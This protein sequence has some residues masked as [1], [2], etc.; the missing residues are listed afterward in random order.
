[1]QPVLERGSID[2]P[3]TFD[4]GFHVSAVHFLF[5]DPLKGKRPENLILCLSRMHARD[6]KS[7]YGYVK[8]NVAINYI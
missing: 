2:K 6:G 5:N 4:E 7:W 1:M 8:A 3:L